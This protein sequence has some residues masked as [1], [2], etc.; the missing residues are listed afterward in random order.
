ME[1]QRQEVW[2]DKI[3]A[4]TYLQKG[5]N[6]QAL[7]TLNRIPTNRSEDLAFVNMMTAVAQEQ[8]IANE[9]M[10]RYYAA[11]I[12]LNPRTNILAESLLSAYFNE[13]YTRNAA[14]IVNGSSKTAPVNFHKFW[15]QLLPNPAK[16]KVTIQWIE[17]PVEENVQL[18]IY[19]ATGRQVSQSIIRVNKEN[20][21]I[22]IGFLQSGIYY[23]QFKGM[24]NIYSFDKLVIVQ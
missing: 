20:E 2:S 7:Q 9:S 8:V 11:D 23:F 18:I 15:L 4:V 1:T 17:T 14:L 13:E 5:E 21:V 19:D 10:I 12:S 3:L 6:A 24:N 16:D 22:E